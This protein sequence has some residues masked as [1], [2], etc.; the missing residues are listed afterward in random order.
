MVPTMHHG[1]SLCQTTNGMLLLSEEK[2]GNKN[3][4]VQNIGACLNGFVMVTSAAKLLN[5]LE[6]PTEKNCA[7]KIQWKAKEN[8]NVQWFGTS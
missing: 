3:Q 6:I 5:T 8:L 1:L 4:F 7:H 2:D